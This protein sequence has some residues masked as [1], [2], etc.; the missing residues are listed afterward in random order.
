MKPKFKL[1]FQLKE[2][3]L[4]IFELNLGIAGLVM[5]ASAISGS[6]TRLYLP[7]TVM[8]SMFPVLLTVGF[9]AWLV[10]RH[11]CLSRAR[12][13]GWG[14]LGATCLSF[15]ALGFG[16]AV[17]KLNATFFSA[18]YQNGLNAAIDDPML[19]QAG[20]TSLLAFLGIGFVF[21]I[22]FIRRA[23]RGPWDDAGSVEALHVQLN[24]LGERVVADWSEQLV[25]RID[26]LVNQ[27]AEREAV[28]AYQAATG[29]RMEDASVVIADWPEH[30]V[31][32]EI[33]LLTKQL[34]AAAIQP[35]AVAS[36]K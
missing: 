7:A 23:G 11:R 12:H 25:S 27:G 5:V 8:A 31:R 18:T 24:Q 20:L 32:L 33:E 21:A 30:R 26:V 6:A 35:S 28:I 10:H 3:A 14:M 17:G 36:A 1:P 16:A 2:I 29:C 4:L 34:T 9:A 22:T 19:K 15:V 13:R